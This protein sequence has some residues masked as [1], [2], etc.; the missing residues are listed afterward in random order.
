MA[1]IAAE[2]RPPVDRF[3]VG[4]ALVCFTLWGSFVLYIPVLHPASP[5]EVVV[6][7]ALGTWAFVLI[8]LLLTR[9]LGAIT[10][11]V[12]N[13]RQ[14]LLLA[15]A[16]LLITSN[17]G[18]YIWAV[19]HARVVEVG[20]GFYLQPILTVVVAV[21]VLRERMRGLQWA[22]VGVATVGMLTLT[23]D[24]GSPPWVAILLG[25]S[26]AVYGLLRNLAGAPAL[27]AVFLETSVV[28]P[29][30]AALLWWLHTSGTGT[31][32]TEGGWHA[33]LL[34]TTG[35]VMGTPM[36]LFG[37]ATTRVPL[38]TL[39]ILQYV[40]PTVAVLLGIFVLGENLS[41]ER[42][43]GLVL[44]WVALAL[45]TVEIVVHRRGATAFTGVEPT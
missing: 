15:V 34:F 40:N 13:R 22:A 14:V 6:Y 7:R 30:M 43:V 11:M 4:A 28:L 25:G 1:K 12:R 27:P 10:V 17:W 35:L 33:F 20:L 2:P 8:A 45:L 32:T 38:A 44:V 41:T 3:G 9:Q 23:L 5:L 18:V 36:V 26:L 24:Y 21:V 42:L 37:I 29:P 39:G 31:L 19:T 16:G